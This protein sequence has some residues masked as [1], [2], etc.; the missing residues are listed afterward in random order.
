MEHQ[1]ILFFLSPNETAKLETLRQIF[2]DEEHSSAL[3]DQVGT[4]FSLTIVQVNVIIYGEVLMQLWTLFFV[5]SERN[6]VIFNL[7]NALHLQ[8]GFIMKEQYLHSNQEF[9]AAVKLVNFQCSKAS[10]KAISTW[11]EN[12]TDDEI[13]NHAND[14]LGPLTRFL[15]VN[16]FLFKGNWKQTFEEEDTHLILFVQKQWLCNRDINDSDHNVSYQALE[17]PKKEEFIFILILPTEDV[18]IEEV[19]KLTAVGTNFISEVSN[20]RLWFNIRSL[21][22]F[23]SYRFTIE[24]MVHLKVFQMLSVTEIFNSGCDLSGITDSPN[25]H[26]S[27]AI[28]KV[29][30]EVPE[31]GSEAAGSTKKDT[32]TC[33]FNLWDAESQRPIGYPHLVWP[34]CQDGLLGCGHCTCYSYLELQ[35]RAEREVG[36]KTEQVA[37]KTSRQA[38]PPEL[39]PL[40]G[41]S[42]L[43]TEKVTCN[44]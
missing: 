33:L 16:A 31:D 21:L 26:I 25:A 11:V 6:A 34:V 29:L 36:T 39:L 30:I 42:K 10:A 37:L 22:I 24:Q 15:L 18:A 1:A 2:V 40:P 43:P 4:N 12:K 17:L 44:Y 19:K 7:A 23:S 5:T 8:E 41:Q 9:Q 32:T 28:E 38:S 27:K 20:L 35:V 13:R 14:G 3:Q